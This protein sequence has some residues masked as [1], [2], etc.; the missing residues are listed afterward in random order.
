[1]Q[2][3]ESEAYTWEGKIV[4]Q[5]EEWG[6]FDGIPPCWRK[7]SKEWFY[8]APP[9]CFLERMFIVFSLFPIYLQFG[10]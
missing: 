3:N 1:M 4:N 2:T 8:L 10:H 9:V 6:E 7:M 5:R